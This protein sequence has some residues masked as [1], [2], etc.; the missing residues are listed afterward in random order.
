MFD[1]DPNCLFNSHLVSMTNLIH[2]LSPSI[3]IIIS[4]YLP[5]PI[6]IYLPLPTFIY[7]FLPICLSIITLIISLSLLILFFLFI[8]NHSTT[9]PFESNS[10][11]IVLTIC[12]TTFQLPILSN[13]T[14]I[15]YF[16]Y[17]T[18]RFYL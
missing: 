3:Y 6:S 17:L 10:D 16:N 12:F 2:S 1:F 13:S 9:I 18:I 8:I 15:D 7:L 14:T 11:L 4:I 5:L